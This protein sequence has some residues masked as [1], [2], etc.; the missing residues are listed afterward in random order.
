MF[1]MDLSHAV[2]LAKEH[3]YRKPAA[4]NR[5][6][7]PTLHVFLREVWKGIMNAKNSSGPNTTD[8]VAIATA[9]RRLFDMMATRRINGNLALPE[10]RAVAV[11]SWLHL[12]VMYDSPAVV[13]L[14]ATAS[15]PEQRLA[16]LGQ[17]VGINAHTKAKA[18]FDLAQPFSY[19]MHA[20]ETRTFNDPAGA[21]LLFNITPP[22]NVAE[23]N[24][25]VV[26]DQYSIATGID[27]KASTVVDGQLQR[28]APPPRQAIPA[29][30]N[31]EHNGRPPALTR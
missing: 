18:L 26:I 17:R 19:L 31:G 30:T 16:K 1:G 4:S 23:L 13:D 14:K 2:E 9:A 24:A 27:L 21:A 22:N 7:I 11:M 6:F 5:D 20:I 15:S 8:P 3:P 28:P 29:R 12:A 10:F 25:E